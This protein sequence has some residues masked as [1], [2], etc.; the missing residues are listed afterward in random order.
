MTPAQPPPAIAVAMYN[1]GSSGSPDAAQ[2]V[3]AEFTTGTPTTP[4][5]TWSITPRPSPQPVNTLDFWDLLFPQAMSQLSEEHPGEPARLLESGHRIRDKT[6]WAQV[7]DQL[8]EAKNKYFE[9][10]SKFKTGF[11]KVYR[12]FADNVSEPANRLTKLVPGGGDL[13]AVAVTPIIGCVQVL[14]E[15]GHCGN[16]IHSEIPTEI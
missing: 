11:R 15:V 14:L 6:N 4:A 10:D 9:V 8:E 7:Y 5:E 16:N 12:G 13:G 1:G 2:T 3:S